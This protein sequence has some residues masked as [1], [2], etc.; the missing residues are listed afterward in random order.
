MIASILLAAGMARRMGGINKLVVEIDGIPIV[1]RVAD[2]LLEANAGPV[3]VVVGHRA[4]DVR[5]AMASRNVVF[6]ENRRYE[7]GLASSLRAAIEAAADAEA[8][9]VALADMPRLRAEH[10]R[11]VV[12][13]YRAGAAIVAPV[14]AG[15]RG[16]PVLFDARH[17]DELRGLEGDVGAR[18]ILERHGVC[19]VPVEDAGIHLDVDTPEMLASL[20]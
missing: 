6:V 17:F 16:H 5:R 11:A 10:V 18:A 1:A 3:L 12:E 2:A 20:R 9:L 13:G 8:A 4:A 19:E 14:Y 7:D 15:R